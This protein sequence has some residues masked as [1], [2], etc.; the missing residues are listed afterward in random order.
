M[1]RIIVTSFDPFFTRT[2]LPSAD[3][4]RQTINARSAST[5][6]AHLLARNPTDAMSWIALGQGFE[7]GGRREDALAATRQALRL[8]PADRQ[9]LKAA[10]ALLSRSGQDRQALLV[11]WRLVDRHPTEGNAA[12]PL[13]GVIAIRRSA[14]D[15]FQRA[16]NEDPAWWR[17][18]MRYLC[19]Q[20]PD[21]APA[22]RLLDARLQAGTATTGD[23]Q[24]LVTR[25]QRDGRWE[26]AFDLFART[27]PGFDRDLF[28]FVFNGGFEVPPSNVGFDWIVASGE[29]GSADVRP[30]DGAG[31]K[32][33]LHLEFASVAFPGPQVRQQLVLP[34]GAYRLEFRAHA[35]RVEPS[36]G[37][38]WSVACAEPASAQSPPL[39]R[40]GRLIGTFDWTHFRHDLTVP[41]GCR[42][43][44]LRLERAGLPHPSG[45]PTELEARPG[46]RM[47]FDD[48]SIRPRE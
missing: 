27:A 40:S 31:G 35:D 38:E 24:C 22:E 12:W 11:L 34:S 15:V 1:W 26:D 48:F 3:P 46:G 2:S 32:H 8:A 39:L 5:G 4:V 7:S 20:S 10:A 28:G 29:G 21:L 30:V 23:R 33:A 43:Q 14:D 16:A 45:G 37:V 17:P 9:T 19:D 25:L 42:V 44:E 6:V 18:F 36:A 47:D 41:P 13:M